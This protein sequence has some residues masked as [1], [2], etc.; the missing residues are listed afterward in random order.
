MIVVQCAACQARIK[1]KDS[2]AGRQVPCPQCKSPIQIP[3]VNPADDAG[4][5]PDQSSAEATAGHS[6]AAAES[7]ASPEIGTPQFPIENVPP[8][9]S[10]SPVAPAFP[11][12]DAA[13]VSLPDVT[14]GSSSSSA[15]SSQTEPLPC[16]CGPSVSSA[17]KRRQRGSGG[18]FVTALVFIVASG[19][20]AWWF[21]LFDKPAPQIALGKVSDQNVVE[22]NKLSV[23]I[24]VKNRKELDGLKFEL[25]DGPEAASVDSTGSFAWLPG[26]SDG[27]GNVSVR[28]K[29]SFGDVSKDVKFGVS[30]A[31]DNQPPEVAKI[32][33]VDVKP[34][35]DI[36]LT[37]TAKDA[38]LPAVALAYELSEDAPQGATIN[39]ETGE[40]T[41]TAADDD[42]GTNVVF[43]VIAREVVPES[44]GYE[45]LSAE[46]VVTIQ[47]APLADP[48]RRLLV[49]LRR[50]AVAY[51]EQTGTDAL[52]FTGK[53]R[54][55]QIADQTVSCF[56]YESSDAVAADVLRIN[57]S[58]GRLF[59]QKWDRDDA[60]NVYQDGTLLVATIGT[61]P[62]TQ[63][64]LEFLLNPPFAVVAKKTDPTPEVRQPPE[65]V[66]ALAEL[67]EARDPRAKKKRMLF[68]L[69]EYNAVR[70]VFAEQ[71]AKKHN[72]DIR[73]AFGDD[74]DD[75]MAWLGEKNDFREELFTAFKPQDDVKAG[76]TLLK[77][78]RAK[79]PKDIE[80]YGSLAIAT[81]VTWDKEHGGVY[82][83]GS[84]QQRTHSIMPA[85]LAVA[86]DNFEYL[87]K[88][89]S[90]MQ[91]R[92]QFV[93]WEFLTLV[94]NHR[95]P[96]R[97]REWALQN[98]VPQ[99]VMF[100]KCY[101]DVPYDH[102]MLETS[103]KV[104]RLDGKDYNL[105][106]I[107]QFGG[108]CAMQADFAARVG[109]SIGVPAAYVSGDGRYGG[110]GHAW[111]M[112]VELKAVSARSISFSLESHGR[113]RGDRYYVGDLRDPHTGER[114]TDRQLEL[115]LHQVGM[116]A[117][118]KRHTERVM[119]LYP[120]LSEEL[121]FGFDEHI[122][123]IT[124]T[125]ALNP[126][127]EAAWTAL[128]QVAVHSRALDKIQTKTMTTALNQLFVNFAAFPDFTLTIFEDL[129]AFE[130]DEAKRVKLWYQLL[131]VYSAA[132]RPDLGFKA[133]MRLTE[134]LVKLQRDNEAIQALAVAIQKYPDE[135]QFVPGMLDA[136][137]NLAAGVDGS[138]SAMVAFYS[139][140]LPKIPQ[141]RGSAPSEYCMQ[142][143]ERGIKIFQSA[144]QPQLAQPWQAQLQTL[145]ASK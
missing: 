42:E 15:A 46:S 20:A 134:T 139:A 110:A 64:L 111:V 114:I 28:I 45:P 101:S 122:D 50:R 13:N 76:L 116:D 91:G 92:I 63:R 104:C 137:E 136:L 66:A 43:S 145:Q 71:F 60:L 25:I 119:L 67:Y 100:G 21:G 79:F 102:E 10:E 57:E 29:V 97:E 87:V 38:D 141:K 6:A 68:S 109:K 78:I 96:L 61:S 49:G 16:N 47:V 94:V 125:L 9:V 55:L 56:E 82:E 115:K 1:A 88:T 80:R 54:L 142:M 4:S 112:W 72:S 105:P 130:P 128:S 34:G 19:G 95:T 5:T 33:T 44:L 26:E 35:G 65:L 12:S 8:V 106:N 23:V 83:Y 36:K 7:P 124:Q 135:G 90:V 69:T 32:E 81:A 85:D 126:W 53:R 127:N 18:F 89:E 138:Q 2:Y 120:E 62:D 11:A 84:H 131:D 98:Y 74:Y 58:E 99:R 93:P 121:K 77:E 3:L 133:L 51:E 103:S 27:P 31:E 117:A 22:G 37:A 123:F 118:A 24:P 48:Y 143:Y 86:L 52:P 40:L 107:R 73:Q 59:D 75:L 14:G 39:A 41:W 132:E 113:Y 129:I 108:V 17:Y 144:G 140:F 70:K 30:V